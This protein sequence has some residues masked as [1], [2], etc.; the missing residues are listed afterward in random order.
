MNHKDGH[1][2]YIYS[3]GFASVRP[4]DGKPVRFVGTH[5]DITQRKLNEEA[6]RESE[7][8]FK[9]IFMNSPINI[10]LYDKSGS[11]IEINPAGCALFGILS[12]DS[13]KGFSLFDNPHI[14]DV[15][16]EQLKKGV[17]ITYES[18]NDFE[19]VKKTEP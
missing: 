8:K 1:I 5:L 4:T 2:I 10:E 7:E 16:L 9:D 18:I 15:L 19:L 12:S 11:L 6:L 17:P 3:R 13:V 14:P